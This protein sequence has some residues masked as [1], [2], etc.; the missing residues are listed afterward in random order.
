MVKFCFNKSLIL[1]LILHSTR[2]LSRSEVCGAPS[3]SQPRAAR[4]ECP[5]DGHR[6]M[7]VRTC[8]H[9]DTDTQTL[10]HMPCQA[11][12]SSCTQ[13]LAKQHLRQG[14]KPQYPQSHTETI[15][16]AHEHAGACSLPTWSPLGGSSCRPDNT[17]SY[18][19]HPGPCCHLSTQFLLTPTPLP[20]YLLP[21]QPK[22][23]QWEWSKWKPPLK[24]QWCPCPRIRQDL[25]PWWGSVR[26][27]EHCKQWLH[28]FLGACPHPT[29]TNE[30]WGCIMDYHESMS[31]NCALGLPQILRF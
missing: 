30:H 15:S 11:A 27:C 1:P 14:T 2:G 29:H 26:R 23:Q 13:L 4:A 31:S 19:P 17:F 21:L 28:V 18:P 12:G 24:K 8:G 3:R 22:T 25:W 7:H 20:F 6:Q 10:Q 5:L 16:P 9:T